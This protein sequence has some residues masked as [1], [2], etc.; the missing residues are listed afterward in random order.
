[1][2]PENLE[3]ASVTELVRAAVD[4]ARELVRLEVALA[5]DEIKTELQATE[6]AA[7]A[8]ALALAAAVVALTMFTMALVLALHAAAWVVA[9]AGAGFLVMGAIAAYAG[10]EALPKNPLE[11]TR[12]RLQSDVREIKENLA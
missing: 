3:D 8:L 12:A 4:D 2:T 5:R 10:Y 7:I 9:V 11:K 1:M 6:R